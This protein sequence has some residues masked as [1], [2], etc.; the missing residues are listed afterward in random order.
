MKRKNCFDCSD[1]LIYK[2][3]DMKSLENFSVGNI[4]KPK[5][6]KNYIKVS[7]EINIEW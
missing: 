5:K 4:I 2:V 6:S 3:A 7:K 1:G